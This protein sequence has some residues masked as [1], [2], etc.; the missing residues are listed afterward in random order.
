M[1]FPSLLALAAVAIA[2]CASLER[3]PAV[4]EA[5]TKQALFLGLPNARFFIDGGAQTA[6]AAEFKAASAREFAYRHDAA[7]PMPRADILALSGGGDNGAFGAGLLV[8]WSERGTRPTFKGVTGVSTGALIAPFAFLGKAYDPA[9]AKLYT[10]VSASDIFDRRPFLAA[11]SA[12]A[13]ADT[14]PLYR[15]ISSYVTDEMVAEIAREYD[16]GRLLMIGTTDLDAGRPVIWNIGAIAKSGHPLAKESIRKILL[17][18]ASIPGLFPPVMFDIELD[19]R[20]FQEMHG[21]G[22]AT[23]QT[24]LYPATISLRNE[25][26][27]PERARR[28]FIVRNG[29]ALEGWKETERKTLAIAGRAVSTLIASNGIGDMYRIYTTTRRDGVDFNLAM[30]EPDFQEPYKGP[31]DQGY[32]TALFEYGRTKAKGGYPWRKVPPGLAVAGNR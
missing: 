23:A 28:V 7:G 20:T 31:F 15:M 24:F 32:M 5:Q 29:K 16:K 14:A 22:G 9:L 25:P 21:D 1:I 13:M 3:L 12:D 2:G 10:D 19:G 6:L 8:G 17:A 30:I 4:P 11:L 26:T 27:L 18:S